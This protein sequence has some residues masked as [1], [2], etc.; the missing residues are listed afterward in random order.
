MPFPIICPPCSAWNTSPTH[1]FYTESQSWKLFLNSI[2]GDAK[3]EGLIHSTM[4]QFHRSPGHEP[5]ASL[6]TLPEYPLW[7]FPIQDGQQPNHL[8]QPGKLWLKVPSNT[9]KKAATQKKKKSTGK[10]KRISKKTSQVKN[11]TSQTGQI[12]I[13]SLSMQRHR[14]TSTKAIA[15]RKPLSLQMDKPRNQLL[16]PLRK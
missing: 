2:K 15:N 7:T 14:K 6:P 13:D 3:S 9:K 11:K 12:G 16:M 4:L 10:L 1:N 8:L 5:L